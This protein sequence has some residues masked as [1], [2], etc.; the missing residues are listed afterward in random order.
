MLL[1]LWGSR[2]RDISLAMFTFHIDDSGTSPSQHVAIATALII[3]SVQIVRLESEWSTFKE[4]ENFKCFHTSEFIHRNPK[5]EFANWDDVKQERVF[6]RVR[7]ISKKYSVRALSIAVNKKDYDEAVPTDLRN[8]LGRDHY[9]WAVRQMLANLAKMYPATPTRRRE[10]IFHW[11]ER[12]HP[13]RNEIEE[14]MDQMQFISEKEGASGDYS[15]PHFG[16]SAEI[17]GLQCVDAVS[18]VCYQYAVHI[19]RKTPLNKFVPESWR[20]FEG[21]LGSDGWLKAL[22]IRREHLERSLSKL[23]PD[24]K[25]AQF[26]KEWTEYKNK[27]HENKSRVR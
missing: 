11:L 27:L 12:D 23:I 5:S 17:P 10:F 13:A 3:P 26:F 22:T 15:D 6:R 19:F 4:K 24:K 7:Q 16:K 21:H 20:E 25:A 1:S 14:I 9:S 2:W 18:W 8:Y